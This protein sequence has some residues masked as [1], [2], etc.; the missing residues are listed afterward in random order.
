[1]SYTV[2]FGVDPGKSGGLAILA[3]E[4]SGFPEVVDVFG[5]KPSDDMVDLINKLKRLILYTKT[6]YRVRPVCFFEKGQ[7]Y[8][9]QGVVSM[10]NYGFTNGCYF[11]PF[12]IFDIPVIN[13]TPKEWQKYH[14]ITVPR[15]KATDKT[16]RRKYLKQQSLSRA[17]S[18][19]PHLSTKIKNNDGISD[20]LLIGMYGLAK[21]SGEIGDG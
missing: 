4:D 10:F 13:V 12:I 1:M 7:A 2:V 16:K 17:K 11:A 5:L 14:K 8:S 6:K 15:K 9:G 20:S 21:L 18:L 19:F 3:R